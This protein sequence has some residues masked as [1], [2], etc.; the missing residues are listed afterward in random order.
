MQQQ[1]L[2]SQPASSN[3]IA[4]AM[5]P[6]S[7]LTVPPALLT[8]TIIPLQYNGDIVHFKAH[9]QPR[10]VWANGY[11]DIWAD[12]DTPH[13]FILPPATPIVFSNNK[14]IRAV[15]RSIGATALYVLPLQAIAP[16]SAFATSHYYQQRFAYGQ[17]AHAYE[18]YQQSISSKSWAARNQQPA[19]HGYYYGNTHYYYSTPVQSSPHA[20]SHSYQPTPSRNPPTYYYQPVTPPPVQNQPRSTGRSGWH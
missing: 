20:P 9:R 2:R 18:R 7:S 15:P 12:G 13:H 10:L 14:E 6:S 19:A 16:V 11:V 5:I 4:Q 8:P 1:A 3:M 17:S